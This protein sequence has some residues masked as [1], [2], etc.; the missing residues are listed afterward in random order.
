[1]RKTII[2]SILICLTFLSC[3]KGSEWQNDEFDENRLV[4]SGLLSSIEETQEVQLSLMKQSL[5]DE[6]EY[7]KDAI[8]T[9]SGTNNTWEFVSDNENPGLYRSLEPF[10]A[11]EGITYTLRVVYKN[12][13]Y[14]AKSLTRKAVDFD[15]LV[16]SFGSATQYGNYYYIAYVAPTY[17]AIQPCIYKV[18]LD[19]SHLP[20]YYYATYD[21][22]HATLY[23]YTLTSLDVSEIFPPTNHFHA[24]PEGTKV[25]QTR[26]MINAEHENYIRALLMETTWNGGYFGTAH[27][28]LPTNI[29]NNGIGFWGSAGAIRKEFVIEKQSE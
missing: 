14:T 28:N 3:E 9:V 13:I 20:L 17:W 22:S 1:M 4:I 24:F 27:G 10:A 26:Y 18:E 25:K 15:P 2:Y 29:S 6:F 8:V 19:W 5:E 23:Y 16:Y 12:E 11:Q 7:A 21:E